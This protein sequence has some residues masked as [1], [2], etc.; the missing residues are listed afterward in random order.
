MSENETVQLAV[1]AVLFAM[2]LVGWPV[3]LYKKVK[4]NGKRKEEDKRKGK[5][6]NLKTG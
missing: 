5:R 1:M 2:F 6:K 4:E 3:F